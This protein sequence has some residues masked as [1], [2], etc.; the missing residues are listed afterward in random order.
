MSSEA[1]PAS[2]RLSDFTSSLLSLAPL[3][4]LT[5]TLKLSSGWLNFHHFTSSPHMAA[6][7]ALFLAFP[8]SADAGLGGSVL[9]SGRL[10]LHRDQSGVPAAHLPAYLL[11][12]ITPPPPFPPLAFYPGFLDLLLTSSFRHQG[13]MVTGR[14]GGKVTLSPQASWYTAAAP[15]MWPQLA[16]HTPHRFGFSPVTTA[17]RQ[18]MRRCMLMLPHTAW[19]QTL[20]L[21][22][23]L[24]PEFHVYSRFN[25]QTYCMF[26]MVITWPIDWVPKTIKAGPAQME[27]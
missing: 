23:A 11:P 10:Y 8:Q 27:K 2:H 15:N 12:F 16:G 19:S 17:T 9:N 22:V 5:C 25:K 24:F 14:L 7:S 1:S 20:E 21:T 13:F 18:L 26:V 3:C 6:A 4:C